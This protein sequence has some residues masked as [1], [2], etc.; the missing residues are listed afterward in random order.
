MSATFT[1][2]RSF[3]AQDGEPD[4]YPAFARVEY[5][6]RTY[7]VIW[8]GSS[9]LVSVEFTRWA[10]LGAIQTVRT[11]RPGPTRAAVLALAV[12]ACA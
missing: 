7:S 6:G 11:L 5:R 2:A 10:G 1:P 8:V 3:T 12:A 4:A 9:V